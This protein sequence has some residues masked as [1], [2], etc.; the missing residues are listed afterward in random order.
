MGLTRCTKRAGVSSANDWHGSRCESPVPLSLEGCLQGWGV[1][2]Y[3]IWLRTHGDILGE[4]P[5]E[6]KCCHESQLANVM[7]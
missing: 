1:G 7:P 4:N 2:V 6:I 3:K 5:A